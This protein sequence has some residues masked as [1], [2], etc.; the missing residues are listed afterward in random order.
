MIKKASSSIAENKRLL[1]SL[2][3]IAHWSE[4]DGPNCT[5]TNSQ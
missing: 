4:I 5:D 2:V 3:P 1:H